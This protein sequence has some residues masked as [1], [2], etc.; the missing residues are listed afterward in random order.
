MIHQTN[1]HQYSIMNYFGHVPLILSK[2]GHCYIGL[3]GE[4]WKITDTVGLLYRLE[5]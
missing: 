4:I 5:D 1:K 3:G 2:L